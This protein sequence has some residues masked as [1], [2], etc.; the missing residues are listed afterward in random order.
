MLSFKEYILLEDKLDALD[1][2]DADPKTFSKFIHTKEYEE[3]VKSQFKWEAINIR[4]KF[5][6]IKASDNVY[7][8]DHQYRVETADNEFQ[9]KIAKEFHTVDTSSL[10]LDYKQ[11]FL[12]F[13]SLESIFPFPEGIV[14][15][16]I[17]KGFIKKLSGSL[18][19]YFP[20]M[21]AHRLGHCLEL[22]SNLYGGME[23]LICNHLERLIPNIFKPDNDVSRNVDIYYDMKNVVRFFIDK[24]KVKSKRTS[25]LSY[26]DEYNEVFAGLCLYG[27]PPL[28]VQD[29]SDEKLNSDMF[30]RRYQ[31]LN[32]KDFVGKLKN[33]IKNTYEEILE[34]SKGKVFAVT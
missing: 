10:Y 7:N 14:Y 17:G 26:G 11:E 2:S 33:A 15:L 4:I 24:D 23:T 3:K 18:P 34:R 32:N 20:W 21:L 6:E 29:E 8:I 19:G 31:L 22:D 5:L 30:T 27:E 28:K 13:P 12:K 1:S 9:K 25:K 16:V